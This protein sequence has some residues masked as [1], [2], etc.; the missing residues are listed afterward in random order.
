M[1][2][3]FLIACSLTAL[4]AATFG[5]CGGNE[6]THS[7]TGGF[8]GAP[9]TGGTQTIPTGTGG[10]A[11]GG[12]GPCYGPPD[13]VCDPAHG[14]GC[15]CPDCSGTAMCS[16]GLICTTDGVCDLYDSCTCVDCWH[17]NYCNT[18]A[19]C[20]DDGKCTSE[21]GCECK[22]CKNEANC[23]GFPG[24]GGGGPGGGGNGGA[25]G[26]GGAAGTSGAGGAATGAGGASSTSTTGTG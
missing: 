9:H 20:R 1:R 6:T 21:E 17:D 13:Q 18:H 10:N 7:E 8:G 22:D 3:I 2:K 14:E 5:G 15:S 23:Q 12:A 24:T 16:A 4:T 26:G 11:I 19:N 25:G